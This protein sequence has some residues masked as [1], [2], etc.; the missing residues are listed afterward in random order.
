MDIISKQDL[1]KHIYDIAYIQGEFKLRSG[2]I[3]NVYFDKYQ[4]ETRPN[5]LNYITEHI[6][7]SILP[8][9]FDLLAGLEMG[10]IPIATALGLKTGK[11]MVFVRKK[12]KEYGT[13]K[14]IEGPNVHNQTLLIIEDVVTSGGQIISSVN[15]L[16]KEGAIIEKAICVIDRE[17]GGSEKL[18]ENGIELISLFTMKQLIPTL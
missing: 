10:G 17:Q 11:S 9:D 6:C 2:Q 18:K 1:A 8:N 14:F 12:A 5:L 4:F 3:S 15:D 13:A 16:R 7:R